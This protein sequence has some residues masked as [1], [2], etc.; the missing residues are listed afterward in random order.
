MN[1]PTTGHLKLEAIHILNV[2]I[3]SGTGDIDGAGGR[4][5]G[6]EGVKGT[7]KGFRR[8]PPQGRDNYRL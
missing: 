7:C 1:P 6:R 3:Q 4:E 2:V 5:G 8:V